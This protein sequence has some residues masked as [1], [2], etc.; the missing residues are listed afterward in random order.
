[1]K[2]LME[3]G[4]VQGKHLACPWFRSFLRE[5]RHR[6]YSF[7]RRVQWNRSGRGSIP[8]SLREAP[9]KISLYHEAPV[10]QHQNLY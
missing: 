4:P 3:N 10:S 7:R 1:M 9:G 5:A 8:P 6:T 2:E